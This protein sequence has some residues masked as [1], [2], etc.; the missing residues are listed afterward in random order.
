MRERVTQDA[1]VRRDESIVPDF[2]SNRQAIAAD[3][4]IN[5]H[6]ENCAGREVVMAVEQGKSRFSHILG[7]DAMGDVHYLSAWANAQHH[8]LHDTDVGIF[9]PEVRQYGDDA[10]HVHPISHN[11]I[12][13]AADSSA[14]RR[15]ANQACVRDARFVLRH[16][17]IRT[18]D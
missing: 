5:D 18:K 15:R 4:R 2:D 9:E 7:L 14:G 1:V 11:A 17:N 6:A 10:G 12:T 3:A 16:Y 13:F 8:R